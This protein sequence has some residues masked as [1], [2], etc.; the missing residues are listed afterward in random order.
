MVHLTAQE[1]SLASK[2]VPPV[3]KIDN[4]FFSK[5]DNHQK[6]ILLT[7]LLKLSSEEHAKNCIK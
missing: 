2:L 3:E 1:K 6:K 7:I 5:I 4:D